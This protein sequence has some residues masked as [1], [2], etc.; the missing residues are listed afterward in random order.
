MQNAKRVLHIRERAEKMQKRGW[1]G[2]RMGTWAVAVNVRV[3]ICVGRIPFL[4]STSPPKP[5]EQLNLHNSLIKF[6]L[7]SLWDLNRGNGMKLI[8]SFFES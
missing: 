8:L 7:F 6:G 2:Q 1:G 4:S 5:Q 3:Q